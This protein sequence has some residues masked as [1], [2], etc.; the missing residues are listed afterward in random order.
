MVFTTFLFFLSPIFYNLKTFR[1]TLPSFDFG[2]PIAGIIINSRIVMMEGKMPN[3]ELFIWNWC[4]AILLLLIGIV[5]LN[6]LGSKAA[7]KL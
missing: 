7:E 2:N 3:M 4:Y 1:E 5:I 6:K